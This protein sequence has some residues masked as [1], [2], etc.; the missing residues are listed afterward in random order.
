MG[1]EDQITESEVLC[2]GPLYTELLI[3][4][5]QTVTLERRKHC[6]SQLFTISS[7]SASVNRSTSVKN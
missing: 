1:L 6:P 5:P 2:E 7:S 4:E 3:G